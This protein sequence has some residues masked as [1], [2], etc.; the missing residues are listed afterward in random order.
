ML[1]RIQSVYLTVVF[2]FAVLLVFL[3]LGKFDYEGLKLILKVTGLD[4][5]AAAPFEI[6][7]G[8]RSIL[9]IFLAFAIM[10]LTIYSVFQYKRRHYQIQLGKFN[11]L[12]HV[13][14][15]VSAFFFID[16]YQENLVNLSFNYGIA[17]FLPLVSMILVLIANK[18]IK[19]DHELVRSAN[20]I[21]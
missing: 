19:R 2:V 3:P 21:R 20:R 12:L 17:I 11:V 1:Q 4:L 13:G 15:V 6:N 8:W 16:Y 10:V 5:P 7:P 18:A 9:L 14:M